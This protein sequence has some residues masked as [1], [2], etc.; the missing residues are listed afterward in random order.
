MWSEDSI[1]RLTM[2]NEKH[3]ICPV[4]KE[5]WLE[6][7][8]PGECPSVVFHREDWTPMEMI[9]DDCAERQERL[10]LA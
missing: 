5:N 1:E 9:C 7:Q 4:C 8:G 6:C 10:M 2:N 3:H